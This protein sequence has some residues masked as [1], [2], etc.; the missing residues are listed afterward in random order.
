[1]SVIDCKWDLGKTA[2]G[3]GPGIRFESG[4]E[5]DGG[6]LTHWC[7]ALQRQEPSHRGGSSP[8]GKGFDMIM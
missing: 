5:F 4:G 8:P 6:V 1:M 3:L 7:L 2:T